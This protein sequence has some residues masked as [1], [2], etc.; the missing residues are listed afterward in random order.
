MYDNIRQRENSPIGLQIRRMR[1]S[2]GWSLAELAGRAGTS[3][4]ALHRY[5][6]GWNRF[7][8]AT[9]RKIAR[10]LGARLEI[11][12]IQ[13]KRTKPKKRLKPE[14]LIMILSPLFWDKK[15]THSDLHDY[16][17]WVL[18]RVL[19]FGEMRQ[20]K[21]AREFFGNDLIEKAIALRVVDAR[22]RNYWNMI[23]HG[24]KNASQGAES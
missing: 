20:V 5:E 11:S 15:L 6:S 16:P 14:Q 21:A 7:E 23:L 12:I 4:P 19:M 24:E 1:L 13:E 2:R 9:L 17:T 8:V 3:A 22:T 10:A 18:G